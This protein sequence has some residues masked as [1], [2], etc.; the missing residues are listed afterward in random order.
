MVRTLFR[1]LRKG[2][3]DEG[4]GGGF[5]LL[6]LLIVIGIIVILAAIVFVALDPA[7]R[8][9]QARDAQ[10][11]SSVNSILNAV[12]QYNVDQKGVFPTQIDGDTGTFQLVGTGAGLD[13]TDFKNAPDPS[14]TCPG[15]TL[16][17]T[18][19]ATVCFANLFDPLVDQPPGYLGQIP[20]DP[21]NGTAENTRYWIN[22]TA[23]NRIEVGACDGEDETVKV[24]R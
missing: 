19:T 18:G 1:K 5:T 9:K 15:R 21:S 23:N 2:D 4:S 22:K 12:L 13:C 8:F 6:E 16:D 3:G 17:I 7:K 24:T 11:W 14:P 10:R 20:Q